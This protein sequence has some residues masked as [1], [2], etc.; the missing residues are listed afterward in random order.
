MGTKSR[1][2]DK[3]EDKGESNDSDSTKYSCQGFTR[4]TIYYV[5][6]TSTN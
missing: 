2:N 3:K 6:F 4:R 5:M 1:N